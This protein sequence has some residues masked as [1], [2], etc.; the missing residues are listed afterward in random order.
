MSF[1]NFLDLR[2][3][4]QQQTRIIERVVFQSR[5]LKSDLF[6]AFSVM[7][8]A[9]FVVWGTTKASVLPDLS[10]ELGVGLE[11]KDG[12]GRAESWSGD[13][14]AEK[15]SG[16]QSEEP[17]MDSR[18]HENDNAGAQTDTNTNTN[19][20]LGSP[21]L[22]EDDNADASSTNYSLPTTNS[23][24][25][26]LVLAPA[27]ESSSTISTSST[28][29]ST[30]TPIL[31]EDLTNTVKEAVNEI[32]DIVTASSTYTSSTT[33]PLITSE[34]TDRGKLVTITA[35]DENPFFPLVDVAASTTIPKIYKVGEESKIKIKWK[36]ENNQE[37]PF[38]ATDTNGDNYL[39]LV[40]W[41]VPHL[42]TQT[43]EI[44]F[45]SKAFQLDENQNIIAD[46]YDQVQAKDGNFASIANGQYV[47]VTFEEIL[48]NSK[49]I[50]VYAKSSS[51]VLSSSGTPGDSSA[52]SGMDSLLQGNDNAGASSTNYSLPTTHSIEVY[53]VYTDADGNQ[54]QGEKLDLVNDGINS[55]F[56]NIATDGHYCPIKI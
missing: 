29:T 2:K 30:F 43:F 6:L 55:D 3:K 34:D 47:R 20:E 44:I 18:I 36:N 46:I 16:L 26:P 12:G 23:S 45:I 40:E 14:S 54:T 41:T 51:S 39:D 9:S 52:D 33:A 24:D 21:G 48:D 17:S 25:V 13:F 15:D 32:T 49:D 27:P 11:R 28:T 19:T 22:P 10:G 50:T 37:M 35:I 31:F 1:K 53:P 4:T 56:S 5:S 8:V 7:L 38:R 42:S